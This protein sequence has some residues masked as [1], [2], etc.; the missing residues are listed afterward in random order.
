MLDVYTY[1]SSIVKVHFHFPD[2]TTTCV[3]IIIVHSEQSNKPL[4]ARLSYS[5]QSTL[6]SFL[7]LL[8]LSNLVGS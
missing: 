4:S 3:Y 7:E 6:K 2:S 5:C 8:C 1:I